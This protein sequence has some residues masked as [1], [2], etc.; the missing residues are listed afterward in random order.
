MKKSVFAGPTLWELP[1][2]IY[3]DFTEKTS[4]WLN[5]IEN[6]A[7]AC[8]NRAVRTLL[9]FE[10]KSKSVVAFWLEAVFWQHFLN[11]QIQILGS[12]LSPTTFEQWG[13]IMCSVN[14][15]PYRILGTIKFKHPWEPFTEIRVLLLVI[16][17]LPV[18]DSMAHY[19]FLACLP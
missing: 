5:N 3:M 11:L 17:F 4:D 18:T 14:K 6:N 8:S 10:E 2:Q 15:L 1:R 16:C 7:N 9:V 13:P 19:K 12:L